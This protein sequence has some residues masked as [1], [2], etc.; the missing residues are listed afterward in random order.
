MKRLN[1][2]EP[3]VRH[4]FASL[5]RWNLPIV[6]TVVVDPKFA[7]EPELEKKISEFV[8]ARVAP[9]LRIK[10]GVRFIDTIP[11]SAAGKILRKDLRVLAAKE[12][13][14]ETKL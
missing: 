12:S 1:T 13:T 8:A 9:H 4:S 10:G 3:T 7:N 2:L 5:E 11:K 6:D 14:G